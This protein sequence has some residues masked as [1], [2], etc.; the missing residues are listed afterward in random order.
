MQAFP[1]RS[2]VHGS[3]QPPKGAQPSPLQLPECPIALAFAQA[4]A[5]VA[6]IRLDEVQGGRLSRH[7]PVPPAFALLP[8]QLVGGLDDPPH[9]PRGGRRVLTLEH[10]LHQGVHGARRAC[11]A[12]EPQ[13]A[14]VLHAPQGRDLA[15]RPQRTS[16]AREQRVGP[17]IALAAAVFAAER[18][19]PSTSA[20]STPYGT[21][22]V[23]RAPSAASRMWNV[24]ARPPPSRRV[25]ARPLSRQPRTTGPVPF[26]AAKHCPT[27]RCLSSRERNGHPAQHERLHPP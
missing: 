17:P 19:R 14:Q 23:A 27:P 9:A 15:S 26:S 4:V 13:Q 21:T 1:A 2:P 24:G 3:A 7:I 12:G 6:F 25:M 10:R 5:Q 11:L 16:L 8:A 22:K 18:V 20:S